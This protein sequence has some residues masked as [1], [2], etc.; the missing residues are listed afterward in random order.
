M[1]GVDAP[2]QTLVA[3]RILVEAGRW[4]PRWCSMLRITP[5][6]G[7]RLTWTSQ[8]HVGGDTPAAVV[9]TI[10]GGHATV[11]RREQVAGTGSAVG[12]PEEGRGQRGRPRRHQGDGPSAAGRA[13][14]HAG[15]HAPPP[16]AQSQAGTP[17]A[18]PTDRSRCCHPKDGTVPFGTHSA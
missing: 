17:R 14:R 7:A 16:P 15:R 9:A 10:Y 2:V 5:S 3:I 8:A 12:V 11:G 4:P 13:D 18:I 6:T 1:V